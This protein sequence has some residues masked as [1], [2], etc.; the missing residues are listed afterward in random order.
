V[1]AAQ[2][3][4]GDDP[5][6]EPDPRLVVGEVSASHLCLLNKFPVL[7]DHL[8]I[9]T[10]VPAAQESALD[11]EDFEALGACLAEAEALGFYNAGPTAGAS[12]PHRHLQLVRLPLGPGGGALPVDSLLREALPQRGLGRAPDLP[13]AHVLALTPG[14][15]R[16]AHALHREMLEAAG[17]TGRPY[18]LL[19]TRIWTLLVPRSRP[20]WEGIEVNALGY[21]G[22]L[23]VR[24]REALERLR[25]IGPLAL[26]AAV[27]VQPPSAA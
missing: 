8:L 18:N 17:S 26:L 6:R 23:L 9:V 4:D 15:P 3:R 27:G 22:A 16:A 2:R 19:I 10:R 25:R 14:D 21:A 11:P 24:D 12:Q 13:F 1:A 5:F 7:D 20:A